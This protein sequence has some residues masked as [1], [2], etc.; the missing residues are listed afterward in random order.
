M[1]NH[2]SPKE[3]PVDTSQTLPQAPSGAHPAFKG[4]DGRA[5]AWLLLLLSLAVVFVAAWLL[6][7]FN[8]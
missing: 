5:R 1:N 4:M 2:N 7:F 6:G 8:L 3:S